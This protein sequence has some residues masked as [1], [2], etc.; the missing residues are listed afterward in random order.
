MHAPTNEHPINICPTLGAFIPQ[1]CKFAVDSD[2]LPDGT[3]IPAG[4][5]LLYP[6]YTINRLPSFWGEDAHQFRWGRG[7]GGEDAHQFRWGGKG[8]GRQRAQREVVSRRYQYGL[9]MGAEQG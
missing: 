6:P 8:G 4:G 7:Q 9:V 5:L 1:D 2:V 3:F